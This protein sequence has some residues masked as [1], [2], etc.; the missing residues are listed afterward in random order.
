MTN[1]Q[2]SGQQRLQSHVDSIAKDLCEG[3]TYEDVG[4]EIDAE[5][6]GYAI[7]DWISGFD[8]LDDVLD[9]NWVLNSDK[10]FRSARI[11]VAFGGPNIWVNFETGKVEGYW[12][13]DYAEAH[14][15]GEFADQVLEA[16]EELYN[17]G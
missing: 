12:G 15:S 13:G 16:L 4:M 3:I 14:F 9:I 2:Q 11:L 17:C 6:N 8:Y 1:T 5:A 7:D 10:T